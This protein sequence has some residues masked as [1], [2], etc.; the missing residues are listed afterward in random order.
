MADQRYA[1][2]ESTRLSTGKNM[3][4]VFISDVAALGE[5]PSFIVDAMAPGSVAY[6]MAP[7]VI[8]H[9]DDGV[10]KD[11]TGTVVG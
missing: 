3:C 6:T 10:W 11:K 5:I 9:R 1:V 2:L 4:N 7:I 8:Y